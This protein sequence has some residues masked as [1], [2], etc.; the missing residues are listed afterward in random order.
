MALHP[1]RFISNRVRSA[2]PIS[3]FSSAEEFTGFKTEPPPAAC[4]QK[5][6]LRDRSTWID[7]CEISAAWI[8]SNKYVS[9]AVLLIE[10]RMAALNSAWPAEPEGLKVELFAIT[11]T[12][13][14]DELGWIPR[15]AVQEPEWEDLSELRS[16]ILRTLTTLGVALIH[17]HEWDSS[18]Q[19]AV[20]IERTTEILAAPRILRFG[21]T[22]VVIAGELIRKQEV[23]LLSN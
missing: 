12:D 7:V 19:R 18:V 3:L 6:G 23:V 11:A 17:R 1:L 14:Y 8:G 22:G 10:D 4:G 15:E 5:A 21:R 20:S 2:L 9:E 13:F 16:A